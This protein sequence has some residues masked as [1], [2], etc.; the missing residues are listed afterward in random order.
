MRPLSLITLLA[1]V[2]LGPARADLTIVQQIQGAGEDG[3]DSGQMV[4]RIKAEKARIDTAPQVTTIIDGRTGE[5][6]NVMNDQK[7]FLRISGQQARAVAETASRFMSKVEATEKP[8]LVAT[9]K[10]ETINGYETAEF[11]S[12]TPGVTTR[13]WIAPAYPDG[14]AILTQLQAVTPRSWGL[15]ENAMPDYR[16]FPGVPVRTRMTIGGKEIT[17][18]LVSVKLDAL[19]DSDFAPPAGFEEL[20]MPDLGKMFGG[21][22]DAKTKPNEP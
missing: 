7:K 8:K 5:I 14:A 2:T 16:N 22:L 19:P 6:V 13:Y 20:K 1:L 3:K 18:T 15:G 12:E 10:K 21:K 17:T 11:I 4:I 9:G